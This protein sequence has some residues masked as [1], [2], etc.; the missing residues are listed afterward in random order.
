MRDLGIYLVAN[1]ES[2]QPRSTLE[3]IEG[4]VAAG[5]QWVQLRAKNETAREFFELTCAAAELTAGKAELLVNDRIDVFLAARAAGAAVTGIHIGQKD[6]AVR[7]AREIIGEGIIGLSASTDE[8]LAGANADAKYLDYLGV[9]AIRATPTKKD[10]P[11]PL[12]IDGFL[13]ANRLTELPCVAIGS[14]TA[15]DAAALRGG[16]AAGM[17]VVRAI[18]AAEDPQAASAE[19]RNLWEGAK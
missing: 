5:V 13:R 18:C 9:G 15:A 19:L 3:V 4:A 1:T 6:I 12:G 17:A 14:L 2:C 8:Q 16:G 10:H 7:Y 11:T